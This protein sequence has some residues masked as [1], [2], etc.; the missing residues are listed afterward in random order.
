MANPLIEEDNPALGEEAVNERIEKQQWQEALDY[1]NDPEDDSSGEMPEEVESFDIPSTDASGLRNEGG[2][3]MRHVPL[4]GREVPDEDVDGRIILRSD[5][6]PW[7][8][9]LPGMQYMGAAF[10]G[11]SNLLNTLQG[12][13]N[14]IEGNSDPEKGEFQWGNIIPEVPEDS[15]LSGGMTDFGR[16]MAQFVVNFMIS[17]KVTA[18]LGLFKNAKKT[19]NALDGIIANFTAFDKD[20]QRL[21]D[22]MEMYPELSNPVTRF[23]QSRREDPI[24]VAKIKHVVETTLTGAGGGV[25]AGKFSEFFMKIL[26]LYRDR[27]YVSAM[28]KRRAQEGTR[29]KPIV[30][31]EF[32]DE[33]LSATRRRQLRKQGESTTSKVFRE[34]EPVSATGK[35]KDIPRKK[36]VYRINYD[37]IDSM[38]NI[39]NLMA[40]VRRWQDE[41]MAAT[42]ENPDLAKLVPAVKQAI[43]DDPNKAI[44]ETLALDPTRASPEEALRARILDVTSAAHVIDVS[45]QVMAGELPED[46]MLRS[47]V[48][49]IKLHR[50]KS[51]IGS[52]W[53]FT[54]KV[55]QEEVSPLEQ[56]LDEFSADLLG[57]LADEGVDI[58]NLDG[59]VGAQ[60]VG[61]FRNVEQ[62]AKFLQSLKGPS[63][64]RMITE[65]WLSILLSGIPTHEVNFSMTS[66]NILNHYIPEKLWTATFDALGGVPPEDRVYFRQLGAGFYKF[67]ETFLDSW[68]LAK[69]A[70]KVSKVGGTS[71]EL[72]EIGGPTTFKLE[73][74]GDPQATVHN[75][76]TLLRSRHGAKKGKGDPSL[77]PFQFDEAGWMAMVLDGT[78]NL[79]RMVGSRPVIVSD[80][81]LKALAYRMNIEE[82]AVHSALA[83][84]LTEGSQEFI[85]YREEIRTNPP[86]ELRIQSQNLARELTFTAEPGSTGEAMEYIVTKFPIMRLPFPFVRTPTQLT[87][88]S[89]EKLPGLNLLLT[90]TRHAILGIGPEKGRPGSSDYG[91]GRGARRSRALAKLAMGA[92]IGLAGWNMA[93]A[94][95]ATGSGPVGPDSKEIRA[96][97]KASG[98]Q[99]DSIVW[100][101][102][103]GSLHYY[104]YDRADPFGMIMGMMVDLKKFRV[105][106]DPEVADD[107]ELAFLLAISKQ[108]MSKT[109]ATNVRKIFDAVMA[110]DRTDARSLKQLVGTVIPR[111]VAHMG[112]NIDPTIRDTRTLFDNIMANTPGMSKY[113]SEKLDWLGAPII[114]E[115]HLWSTLTPTRYSTTSG[116]KDNDLRLEAAAVGARFAVP[117]GYAVDEEGAAVNITAPQEHW[118]VR[119]IAV[120]VKSKRKNKDGKEVEMNF[121]EYMRD[122]I[123][124]EGYQLTKTGKQDRFGEDIKRSTTNAERA[125]AWREAYNSFKKKAIVDFKRKY[126][127]VADRFRRILELQLTKRTGID[128]T[129]SI[130]IPR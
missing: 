56:A 87:K 33:G 106:V 104:S 2:F 63:A 35:V 46:E 93:K 9:K 78:F 108:M 77:L 11:V 22:L 32:P 15:S 64:G 117:D 49:F 57:A 123:Q 37:V 97:L 96:T 115:G 50:Q 40:A 28:N 102:D 114:D 29:D 18:G 124:T 109:W 16:P 112:K 129:G 126:P 91:K 45:N 27:R 25:A 73:G 76:N 31:E 116:R 55:L 99:E 12:I 67:N 74:F 26:R 19:K 118:L 39:K 95:T 36:P 42:L 70:W 34:G 85:D 92:S 69:A 3:E 100:Q 47:L 6:M 54:G 52:T 41:D 61:S 105:R 44:E 82:Q 110:P 83:E 79:F 81:F 60:M 51:K 66:L 94:G 72:E 24:V 125:M 20:H 23:L 111:L 75:I 84:G 17:K 4:R 127:E 107:A 68:R 120:G 98:W 86:K 38:Q 122:R 71:K 103:D 14:Y 5:N 7:A 59:M 62:R 119:Q 128:H 130:P 90:D 30:R 8:H 10:D 80:T 113:L 48:M 88:S 89:F 58:E 65:L 53:G 121:L 101:A 21:S 1:L 43:L 13:T